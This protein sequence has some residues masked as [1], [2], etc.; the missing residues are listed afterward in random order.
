MWKRILYI[1]IILIF[2]FCFHFIVTFSAGRV[3]WHFYAPDCS[4]FLSSHFLTEFLFVFELYIT[5]EHS[6]KGRRTIIKRSAAMK[7]EDIASR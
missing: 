1:I 7:N 4:L 6:R 3:F 2:C 5:E